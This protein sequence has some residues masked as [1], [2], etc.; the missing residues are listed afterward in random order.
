MSSEP[1]FCDS[2]VV[3][4]RRHLRSRPWGTRSAD[5]T[6]G[7]GSSRRHCSVVGLVVASVAV[8]LIELAA[9]WELVLYFAAI[10]VVLPAEPCG[11]SR[12]AAPTIR[13]QRRST[14]NDVDRRGH[15]SGSPIRRS[16]RACKAGGVQ[17]RQRRIRM[18]TATRPA[19]TA[20]WKS[21]RSRREPNQRCAVVR[22][23][24]WPTPAR[25]RDT[26]VGCAWTCR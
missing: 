17:V 23:V 19:M 15:V 14:D 26:L 2:A 12:V 24:S 18:H 8:K 11:S 7:V 9:P 10:V 20:G 25:G 6:T 1:A 3:G 5:G 4:S 21:I 16:G 13:R 22:D